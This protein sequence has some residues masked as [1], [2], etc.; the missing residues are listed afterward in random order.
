MRLLPTLLAVLA[1]A[2]VPA[3]TAVGAA[4]TG[5]IVVLKAGGNPVAVAAQQAQTLGLNVSYVYTNALQGYAAQVPDSALAE[6][7][8]DPRV[9]YVERDQVMHATTTQPNA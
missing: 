2:L 9:A 7:R 3:A 6:L 5:Y 1:I 4:S 8:A